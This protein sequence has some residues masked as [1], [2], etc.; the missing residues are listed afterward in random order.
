MGKGVRDPAVEKADA[1]RRRHR[2]RVAQEDHQ[3][4]DEVRRRFHL[5]GVD[6]CSEAAS[7]NKLLGILGPS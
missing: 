3:Q 7:F 1:G 2:L 5:G 4:R 6:D